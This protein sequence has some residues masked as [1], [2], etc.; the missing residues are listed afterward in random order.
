MASWATNF[1]CRL[2]FRFAL[3]AGN[4]M[5]AYLDTLLRQDITNVH[6]TAS[7][8]APRLPPQLRCMGCKRLPHRGDDALISSEQ[9]P[10]EFQ[11]DAS[12][13]PEDEPGSKVLIGV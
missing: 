1:C 4:S 8:V 11:A 12:A 6:L 7:M 5:T 10:H 13:R 9:L 2:A 3:T